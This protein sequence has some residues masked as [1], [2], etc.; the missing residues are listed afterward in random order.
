MEFY[1]L[2]RLYNQNFECMEISQKVV[3]FLFTFIPVLVVFG[4]VL[5]LIGIVITSRPNFKSSSKAYFNSQYKFNFLYQLISI[6]IFIS[7]NY[8]RY[9][10]DNF[11]FKNN[12][13]TYFKLKIYLNI[14][15]NILLYCLIW[16]FMFTSLD[17]CFI[18]I[19]KFH[20]NLNY[21][22]LNRKLF[23]H[24]QVQFSYQQKL[25]HQQQ[26]RLRQN[27]NSVGVTEILES[28]SNLSESQNNEMKDSPIPNRLEFSNFFSQNE[29][30][31]YFSD[32]LNEDNAIVESNYEE[33]SK[34]KKKIP[35]SD[36]VS[37]FSKKIINFSRSSIIILSILVVI[38]QFYGFNVRENILA[39]SPSTI[40][41]SFVD[42]KDFYFVRH[43]KQQLKNSTCHSGTFD[44]KRLHMLRNLAL[45]FVL[46]TQLD[47]KTNDT[48]T[49]MKSSHKNFF[50]QQ[51]F[52]SLASM[53]YSY[54][55][56]VKKCKDF[57]VKYDASKLTRP[58][59]MTK[60]IDILNISLVC[61]GKSS[62]NDFLAYNTIYFWFEHT[63][64]ISAPISIVFVV[65]SS[66]I[67]LYAHNTKLLIQQEKIARKRIKMIKIQEQN[68]MAK[69]G[70][71]NAS[72]GSNRCETQLNCSDDLLNASLASLKS[73]KKTS[74]KLG[75]IQR[76]DQNL[77]LMFIIDLTIYTFFALPY[78]CSRLILDLFSKH[79]E[80]I[81][82][83]FYVYYYF[84]FILFQFS[85]LFK[86]LL[87]VVFDVKFRLSFARLFL[88]KPSTCLISGYNEEY[89]RK[90]HKNNE[91]CHLLRCLC[92]FWCLN[93]K[94]STQ[95]ENFNI[96]YDFNQ[97]VD[98]NSTDFNSK[99]HQYNRP[100]DP[101]LDI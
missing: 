81:N 21:N 70:T 13:T 95:T 91:N 65:I 79:Y 11:Y 97:D 29:N 43:D 34:W 30:F 40:P 77:N 35:K 73:H 61:I 8:E 31:N 75:L 72:I 18:S 42:E 93:W 36:Q 80:E 49:K 94:K 87:M 1:E 64:V 51:G 6:L 62:W 54:C 69:F 59:L 27:K 98:E 57:M 24:Q 12:K 84:V 83:D 60:K 44:P 92:P 58:S 45:G 74:K 82:L 86:L 41:K 47:K 26:S 99:L 63:L 4:S 17:Y 5:S 32:G 50:T 10:I 96:H 78:F 39:I 37:Y 28:A 53:K 16:N 100:A 46:R 88:F 55:N 56:I 66:F 25:L 101:D 14:A 90:Y 2:N 15:Y 19:I 68:S 67:Y 76:E 3:N 71:L 38:P 89:Y 52:L 22:Q 23:Y 48:I 7:N 9:L 85:L 20:Y 33:R